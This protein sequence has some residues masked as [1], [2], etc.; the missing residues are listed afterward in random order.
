MSK[1]SF[2]ALSDEELIRKIREG[3]IVGIDYLMEKN[4]NL[5]GTGKIE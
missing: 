5:Y 1:D 2:Q 3:D 4:K